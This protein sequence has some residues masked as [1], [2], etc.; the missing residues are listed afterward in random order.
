MPIYRFRDDTT[1][2]EFEETMPM[3]DREDFLKKNPNYSQVF[4]SL[5]IGDSVK[6]GITKPPPEF[7]KGVVGRMQESIPGNRLKE[8]GKFQIPK[9]L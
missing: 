1:G 7:M 9:E 2:D 8:N 5:N 6:L 4:T 3:S